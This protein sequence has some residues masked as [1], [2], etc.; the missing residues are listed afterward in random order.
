MAISRFGVIQR[1][2]LSGVLA[3]VLFLIGFGLL[4]DTPDTRD[5]EREVAAWFVQHRN[6]VFQSVFVLTLAVA[7]MIW[8]VA[9]IAEALDGVA[10][11]V[12]LCGA[13]LTAAVVLLGNALIYGA[14]SYVVGQETPN[15]AKALFE[16]TLVV[17]N[18]TGV[19]M[20]LVIAATATADVLPHWVRGISIVAAA[21]TACSGLAVRSRGTFSPDVG[22]QIVWQIFVLWLIV[23]GIVLA[24]RPVRVPVRSVVELGRR[25]R[26]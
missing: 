20:A 13:T 10:R 19:G 3:G 26:G 6:D 18:V 7:T 14:L 4:G 2:A 23:V 21:V 5:T 24:R 15:S 9:I 17:S 25:S 8:F 1:R 16:L 11:S 12:A 22:Q